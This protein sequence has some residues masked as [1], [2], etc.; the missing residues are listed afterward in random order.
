LAE[1]Q[2]KFGPLPGVASDYGFFDCV[3][4]SREGLVAI[5]TNRYSVPAHLMGRALTARI[6]TRRIE[7]F[8]GPQLVATHV[9][10]PAG[11]HARL[12]DP[13]HFEAAFVGKPR[14]RVM[15]Y[16]DWLCS[17]SPVVMSYVQEISHKRRKEL[18]QQMVA[19]YDLAQ[20][21]GK[22]DFVA[23]L[24]LAAE[25]QMYGAE[26]VQAILSLSRSG[27]PGESAEMDLGALLP[28]VPAQHEIERDLAQYEYYVANRDSV[29]AGPLPARG[30]RP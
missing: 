30:G 15:V 20:E 17:L 26:Y 24:E 21:I 29:G 6:H 7:L 11:H 28:S 2:P 12:I 22:A 10:L 14:G 3:V 19:L 13:R 18:N 25:Q 16:R 5:E 8:A 9:R 4:V 1:E 27:A 23:A